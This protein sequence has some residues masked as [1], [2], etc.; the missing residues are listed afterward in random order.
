M[1]IGFL[2]CY[3]SGPVLIL[4]SLRFKYVFTNIFIYDMNSEIWY[5]TNH[6]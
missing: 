4:L 3:L 2:F 1:L 6:T 5:N